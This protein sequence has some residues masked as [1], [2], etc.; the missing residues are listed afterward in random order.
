M[1]GQ[2]TPKSMFGAVGLY[3]TDVFFGIVA[4][5][6][7]Y[8]KV[9]GEV[10]V[11]TTAY[12]PNYFLKCR[13]VDSGEPVYIRMGQTVVLDWAPF[14]TAFDAPPAAGAPLVTEEYDKFRNMTVVKIPSADSRLSHRFKFQFPQFGAFA[15]YPGKKPKSRP[16]SATI[17]FVSQSADW[18]YLK[19][20]HVAM[21]ADGKRISMERTK[22][23]GT[24]GNGYVIEHIYST[25]N[26]AEVLKLSS[27]KTVEAKICNTEITLSP[28]NMVDLKEF[29]RLLTPQSAH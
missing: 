28:Q 11:G 5:D 7:L 4:A 15:I 3:Y 19:C 6:T 20:H 13:L 29:A 9:E 10:I 14:G 27:A 23:D 18:G 1:V 17:S 25:L 8:L 22:H 16:E 2:V 12:V 24:V 21:L 26:W